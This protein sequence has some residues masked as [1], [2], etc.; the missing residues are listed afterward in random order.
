MNPRVRVE[1]IWSVLSTIKNN[2]SY[3][4]QNRLFAILRKKSNWSVSAFGDSQICNDNNIFYSLFLFV[5]FFVFF[6][7]FSL[8][9]FVFQYF[10]SV[11]C[12]LSYLF[13]P[14]LSF[15]CH[16]IDTMQLF[17]FPSPE[18]FSIFR[19][20]WNLPIF[21]SGSQFFKKWLYFI[22]YFVLYFSSLFFLL[23]FWI[24]SNSDW[25]WAIHLK[26]K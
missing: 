26:I 8:S 3:T 16:F 23:N 25:N 17:S 19:H 20:L 5:C 21:L 12:F 24:S 13:F 2:L 14:L 1:L 9:D 10:I 15:V 7:I 22:I 11:V 6:F 4:Q 18:I